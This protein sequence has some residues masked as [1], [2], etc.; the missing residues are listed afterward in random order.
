[1]KAALLI[2]I[3][4]TILTINL[5]NN[6]CFEENILIIGNQIDY[7]Q[8]AIDN[9]IEQ[10]FWFK[11]QGDQ[12]IFTS[13]IKNGTYKIFKSSL[14]EISWEN[15]LKKCEIKNIPK[16]FCIE[17]K[18]GRVDSFYLT[19]QVFTIQKKSPK[20]I[21]NPARE[22]YQFYTNSKLRINKKWTWNTSFNFK[23]G[24]NTVFKY[25][26]IHEESPY[27]SDDEK[28]EGIYFQIPNGIEEFNFKNEELQKIALFYESISE[29]NSY[30]KNVTKGL[31]SGNLINGKWLI[32][33]SID[34]LNFER[35]FTPSK[36][37]NL[38]E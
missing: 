30:K 5:A 2:L 18:L 35:T 1:M 26:F 13:P 27:W 11:L 17:F 7:P 24:K 22:E 16:L 28:I 34:E 15:L 31:I 29:G 4:F 8:V 14:H 10:K 3:Q 9:G 20:F 32:K 36:N 21:L 33:L 19:N 23:K 25:L 6:N 37:K 38:R 12:I